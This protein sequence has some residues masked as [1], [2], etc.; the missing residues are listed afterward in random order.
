MLIRVLVNRQKNPNPLFRQPLLNHRR[1]IPRIILTIR[2]HPHQHLVI[3]PL[4]NPQPRH[5]FA[6]GKKVGRPAKVGRRHKWVANLPR[7]RKCSIRSV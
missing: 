4:R 5:C 6:V 1:P 3:Q 2:L 7:N